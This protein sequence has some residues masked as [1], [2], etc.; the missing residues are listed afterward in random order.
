M[1][2]VFS[3]KVFLRQ[4]LKT[5]ILFLLLIGC[6]GLAVFAGDP[7]SDFSDRYDRLNSFSADFEQTNYDVFQDG[8]VKAKGKFHLKKP[9]LMRW[10]Y[11]SPEVQ[12]I[13]V[14][15]R[16]V[17]LYDPFFNNVTLSKIE[18]VELFGSLFFFTNS[19]SVK[20]GFVALEEPTETLL[21]EF[22]G[23]KSLLFLRPLEA[24]RHFGEL[25]LALTEDKLIRLMAIFDASSNYRLFVFSNHVANPAYDRRFFTFEIPEGIEII[26]N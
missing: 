19:D 6:S 23:E 25:H 8:F 15:R 14:N 2:P 18:D 13:Y 24:N 7:L 9:G 20:K 17:L 5:R 11:E 4:N 21:E 16:E 1:T 26:E 10:E 12:S 3:R 22:A